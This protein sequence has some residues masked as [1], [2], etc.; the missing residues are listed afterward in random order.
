MKHVLPCGHFHQIFKV[1]TDQLYYLW[2]IDKKRFVKM[3]FRSVQRAYL[4][5]FKQMG[6]TPGV[7]MVF[8]SHGERICVQ[9]HVHCAV[10]MGGVTKDGDWV[11]IKKLNEKRLES[12]YRRF[13]FEEMDRLYKNP[14]WSV[15]YLFARNC[16]EKKVTLYT[17]VH[18]ESAEAIIS[19]LSKS[20]CGLIVW[21]DDLTFDRERDMAII[22]DRKNDRDYELSAD[23]F[24]RR[25][26][27]HVPTDGE[28][29]IRHY[30]LYSNRYK[31][32]REAIRHRVF[33]DRIQKEDSV[34]V[35]S[36][37]G[38]PLRVER[39]FT[40]DTIPL[41]IRLHLNKGSPPKHGELLAA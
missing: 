15:P 20:L 41:E 18:K 29:L 40:Y 2:K 23:E 21:E 27:E 19:Y 31:D 3:M 12:N 14:K 34:E 9:L 4:K 5:E 39:E 33:K 6:I 38:A 30:G 25:Y 11:P 22:H 16:N 32:T 7:F 8:Q 37:C 24:M 13:F 10:S 28:V 26:W 36:E 17:T 35:C 1:P